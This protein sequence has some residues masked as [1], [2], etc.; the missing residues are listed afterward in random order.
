MVSSLNYLA[1]YTKI[2]IIFAVGVL[3]RFLSNP[4][5]QHIKATR[6]IFEYLQGIIMYI[7]ILGGKNIKEI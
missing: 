1:T 6:C 2:N 4:L 7:I 5:L 3:S